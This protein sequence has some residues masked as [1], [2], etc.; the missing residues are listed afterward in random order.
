MKKSQMV[1][2]LRGVQERLK[3][4]KGNNL[5]AKK[6]GTTIFVCDTMS[7]PNTHFYKIA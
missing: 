1:T 5:E 6:A 7:L 4:S 3:K 2:D